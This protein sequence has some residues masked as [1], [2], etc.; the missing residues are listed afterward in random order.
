MEVGSQGSREERRGAQTLLFVCDR[1]PETRL[2]SDP[3]VCGGCLFSASFWGHC[4]VL[5]H[6]L[7]RDDCFF[8]AF[9]GSPVWRSPRLPCD[10]RRERLHSWL[11]CRFTAAWRPCGA[12]A[13]AQEASAFS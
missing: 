9:P 5:F 11:F 3:L 4:R 7:C 1:H 12:G 8:G 13:R 2:V 10:R 6:V